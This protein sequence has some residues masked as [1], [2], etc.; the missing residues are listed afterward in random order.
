M[1]IE[2]YIVVIITLFIGSLIYATFGFGDALFAM[3]ILTLFLGTQTATPL[4]TLNGLL[5]SSFMLIMHYQYIVWKDVIRLLLG[6]V[7]GIPIGIFFLKNGNEHAIKIILGLVIILSVVYNW[8]FRKQHQ[9][10]I[11]TNFAYLFGFIAGILGGAFNTGGPP[12]VIYGTLSNWQPNYFIGSLQAYFVPNDIM[13][14]IGQIS[15]GLMTLA[16]VKLYAFAFP[17]VMLALYLGRKIRQRISVEK[18]NIYIYILL[19]L[20]GSFLVIQTILKLLL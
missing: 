7:L 17:L 1:P 13:I 10:I 2:L 5:L 14:I 6:A 3:P 8:K 4:M 9:H 15:S 12:L 20:L 19:L 16:I 18:F 11:N